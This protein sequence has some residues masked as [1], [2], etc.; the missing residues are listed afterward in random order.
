MTGA[1]WEAGT[2]KR[3]RCFALDHAAG[4]SGLLDCAEEFLFVHL[5]AAL[6][7]RVA[8]ALQDGADLLARRDA[9]LPQVVPTDGETRDGPTCHLGEKRFL[10]LVLEQLT[11]FRLNIYLPALQT[12]T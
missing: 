4:T 1:A 7:P 12:H 10:S 11:D 5:V 9:H 3:V 8:K 6:F 2:K